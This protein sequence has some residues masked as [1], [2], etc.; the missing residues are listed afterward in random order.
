MSSAVV[1]HGHGPAPALAQIWAELLDLD[2]AALEPDVSFLRLGGDS[3][4]A[5]RMAALIRKR[6]GVVL[7]LA[8]V[9]VESTLEDVAAIVSRRAAAGTAVRA[10]PV[11]LR[12]LPS[13]P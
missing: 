5:V 2:P 7:A 3:V 10:L 1:K 12:P 8:D 4:L 9:G 13:A 6:T 11:E